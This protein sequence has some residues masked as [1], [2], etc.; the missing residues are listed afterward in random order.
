MY[1]PGVAPAALLEGTAD[2]QSRLQ[3]M[4]C[5]NATRH[6]QRVNVCAGTRWRATSRSTL[7]LHVVT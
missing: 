6:G 7:K 2:P 1:E 4:M 3:F 5:D